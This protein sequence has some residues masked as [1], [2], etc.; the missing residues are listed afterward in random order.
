MSLTDDFARFAVKVKTR[1]QSTFLGVATKA[2][3]SITVGHPATGAPGQPVD[4]GNLVN[5]WTLSFELGRTA[6]IS[7]NVAYAPP[8]E[9]GIAASGKPIQFRSAVGGAHSVKLTV[10]NADALQAE[11]LA[12]LGP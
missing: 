6:T 10:A 2:H 12:E 5:S 1:T 8:I 4:I 9:D 11:A 7:T 3:Q